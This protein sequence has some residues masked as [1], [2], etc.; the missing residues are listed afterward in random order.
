MTEAMR[1]VW[2]VEAD[3]FDDQPDHGL[4]DTVVRT[5]WWQLL[6]GV[7]PCAPAR[8]LDLGSGTGSLAVLLA[9]HGYEVLGVDFAPRMVER[10]IAKATDQGV[11]VN[12]RLGDA[13]APPV[14]G[15]FD[16]LLVRHVLWALPDPRAALDRWLRLLTPTGV[17]VLIEG[18]W[19]TGAGIAAKDLLALAEPM[20]RTMTWRRLDDE[21]TLWG[22]PVSDERYVI[23]A[24]A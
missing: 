9:H 7:L 6:A 3:V 21:P 23:T 17:L 15:L 19:H 10:A 2:D 24:R 1:A 22:G 5:A 13:A 20:T 11:C 18:V 8:V 4:R 12:F 16:A 14:E